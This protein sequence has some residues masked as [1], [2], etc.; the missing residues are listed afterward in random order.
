MLLHK[1]NTLMINRLLTKISLIEFNLI[2][3]ILSKD[4]EGHNSSS[5]DVPLGDQVAFQL[6]LQTV[7]I[8]PQDVVGDVEVD[9]V[10]ELTAGDVEEPIEIASPRHPEG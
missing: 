1:R 8:P 6:P 3:T 7:V 9:V 5:M 10:V 2:C 4:I